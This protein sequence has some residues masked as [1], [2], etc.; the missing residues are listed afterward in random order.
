MGAWGPGLWSDDTASDVR[1]TYREALEDGLSDEDATAK[2][3]AEFAAELADQDTSP[4]VSLALA[5]SQHDR[6]RLTGEI[7]DRALEVLRS[8]ADWRRWQ[9]AEPR[10]RARRAAVLAR[11]GDQLAGPQP[12][13]QPVRRPARHVTALKPGDV[14]AFPAP[15][16]RFRL[17]AVRAVV[18]G[19]HGAFPFVRLLDFHR[20]HLPAGRE[21]AKLRDQRAGR[22]SDR[23]RPA[24]PW[25]SVDSVVLHSRGR[26]F[27]DYGFKIIGQVPAPPETEQEK[28]GT[29]LA[30]YSG[31]QF[32]QEYLRGHDELLGQRLESKRCG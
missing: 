21:L 28:L 14:L 9:D 1:A 30:S 23:D 12:A 10:V 25:W 19:R 2:V 22:G 11:V 13:G 31:W 29:S 17:L 7:G 16:G 8:G 27:A 24:E 26:D 5:V 6:G 3:L 20:D 15:S 18:E 32:W 4:V